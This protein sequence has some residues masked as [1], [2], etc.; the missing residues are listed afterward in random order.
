MAKL[1][2][3]SFPPG[4]IIDTK[5]VYEFLYEIVGDATIEK[6]PVEYR[7]VAVDIKTGEEIIFDRGRLI[8]AMVASMAIP[9][10][11]SPYH[12]HGRYLSDGG[13]RNPIPWNLANEMGTHN[14]VVNVRPDF[15]K[16]GEAQVR[17]SNEIKET[18]N[19]EREKPKK[20]K[21][22]I[23][24]AIG[25]AIKKIGEN[26]RQDLVKALT[27]RKKDVPPLVVIFENTVHIATGGAPEAKALD[28]GALIQINPDLSEFLLS[29]FDDA[30]PM[31]DIGY[32][33]AKEHGNE[34]NDFATLLVRREDNATAKD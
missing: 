23:F 11:F 26:K 7:S 15:P 21:K 32:A 18:Q 17:V 33:C 8:D 10:V 14:I 6:L 30:D 16:F 2:F 3:P 29:D 13:L 20:D 12:V 31:I 25:E 34:I 22:N 1:F 5:G 19:G 28:E 4:G 9:G 24:E 27:E